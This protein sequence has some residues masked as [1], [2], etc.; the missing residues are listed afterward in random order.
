MHFHP[1]QEEYVQVVEGRLGV[2]IEGQELVL[3]PDDGEFC[4]KPWANHRLCPPGLAVAES[5][6]KTV[7]VLSGQETEQAYRLDTVFFEN[8]YAYQ[9]KIVVGGQKV[10]L[11][12]V[13]SVSYP[14]SPRVKCLP[15]SITKISALVSLPLTERKP[16]DVRRWRFLSLIPM[17]D[18]IWPK[19]F[20][21]SRHLDG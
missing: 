7:F 5:F 2:D 21:S 11:I 12:Q 18:T 20:Q 14:T 9:D 19:P 16:P 10:D 6:P 8:W 4:I 1:Y 3:G 17:V 13:M 15:F